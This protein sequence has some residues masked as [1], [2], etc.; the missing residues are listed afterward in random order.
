MTVTTR[1][2][3]EVPEVLRAYSPRLAGFFATWLHGYF[4]RQF[5]AVRTAGP[6]RSVLARTDAPILVCT[7]HPS[8]WDPIHFLLLAR[9]LRPDG[10]M[11]GPFDAEALKQYG[12]FRRIGGFGV[13]ATTRRG[14]ADFLRTSTAILERPDASLWITAQGE[15]SDPRQR[16]IVLRPGVAHLA[17]RLDRGIVL[18]V[19]VEYPFWDERRPEALSYV[20]EPVELSATDEPTTDAWSERLTEGLEHAM[21]R[22]GAL[23]RTR[24]PEAFETLVLGRTGVGGVYD[25]WRRFAALARGRAFQ[26]SHGARR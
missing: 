26:A 20:G 14:A 23:A 6:G 5:D 21:D 22:L 13:D 24:D 7:N 3:D 16:P 12:F 8:W 25:A 2:R 10:P 19:A 18:P 11:F 4:A 15:F 1:R 17:R 9:R